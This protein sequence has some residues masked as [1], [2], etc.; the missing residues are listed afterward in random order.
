M[1]AAEAVAMRYRLLAAAVAASA[2]VPSAASAQVQ[3]PPAGT[4][5]GPEAGS[6]NV[7][8]TRSF[9]VAPGV[10]RIGTPM[11][12]AFR[13]NAPAPKV[14]VRIVLQRTTDG[15]PVGG[16]KF[17]WVRSGSDVAR[18][19]TPRVGTG[20]FTAVLRAVDS[21]GHPLL[22]SAA[23]SFPVTLKA[24][25]KPA[26]IISANGGVF[27]LTGSSWSFGGDDARFGA[28]RNGHTHQGQD[29]TAPEGTPIVSPHAGVVYFRGV[30]S[31]GAGHY[32]VIT[33][34]DGRD[35]VFMHLVAGSELVDKGDTVK[36]GQPI[37]QVG[38]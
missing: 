18:R 21:Y 36:A 26:P 1:R 28:K 19:W 3:G 33:G 10:V 2:L 9:S 24:A 15:K 20:R 4:P 14:R 11:T 12:A 34:D 38:T 25:P 29:I 8:T 16:L 17:G 37:G 13:V 27:P 23:T 7:V 22:Q 32:L 31:G 6:T 35:Y 30:Q 5:G